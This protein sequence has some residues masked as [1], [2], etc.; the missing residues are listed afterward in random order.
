MDIRSVDLNLLVVFDAMVEHRNVT[1]A[2]ESLGLSQPAMSAAVGRL[3]TVFDDPLFVKSGAQMRPTPRAT[4]L[5]APVRLVLDT[6]KGDILKAPRFDPANAQRRFTILAPDIAEI[7][8]LPLVLKRFAVQAPGATL[9]TLSIPVH[10]A[11]E[12]LESGNADLALGYFPDLHRAGFYQQ[13]LFDAHLVCMVRRKHPIFGNSSNSGATITLKQYLAASHVLVRPDG[14]EHVF[15]QVLQERGLK[16][17]VVLEISHYMSLLPIIAGSD[18]VATV[19]QD[20]A[21][22]C[23]R[24]ADIRLLSP[25]I[26]TPAVQVHQFWHS[27]S[28]KDPAN[29]WLRGLLHTLFG[30]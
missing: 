29:M 20:L 28:H 3:R 9:R 8:L 23:A 1:R 4:E 27:R 19:P 24:H 7:K 15:D 30:G 6:V 11:A 18:L 5:A 26:K 10:S 2:A 25:P 22:V 12:T 21:E 17:R 16:R 14:R 13:R